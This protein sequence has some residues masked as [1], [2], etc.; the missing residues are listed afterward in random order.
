MITK[1]AIENL[2]RGELTF[3]NVATYLQIFFNAH[4]S[5]LEVTT[6][7][8]LII[9]KVLYENKKLNKVFNHSFTFYRYGEQEE[10][11]KFIDLLTDNYPHPQ[12][13]IERNGDDL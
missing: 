5:K 9:V 4:I 7:D 8:K 1:D 11:E 10:L 2:S 12:F 6:T 3:L 13:E